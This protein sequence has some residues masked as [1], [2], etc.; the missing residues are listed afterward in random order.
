MT[1]IIFNKISNF[2][3]YFSSNIPRKIGT[4]RNNLG[5][6]VTVLDLKT[7]ES[8]EFVS[9]AKAARFFNTHPKTI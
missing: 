6:S 9:I 7:K 1:K 5:I 8:Y 4:K 2:K 3:N